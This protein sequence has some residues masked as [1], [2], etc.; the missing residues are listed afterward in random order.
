MIGTPASGSA[1]CQTGA[2]QSDGVYLYFC[3]APN[4]W[5]RAALSSF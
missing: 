4:S 1:A 5:K 3:S 2:P